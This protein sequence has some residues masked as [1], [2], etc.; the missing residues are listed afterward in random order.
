[1]SNIV[2]IPAYNEQDSIG[3]VIKDL[4]KNL[5]HRIIVVNN[6]STDNTSMEASKAGAMVVNE[7]RQ[8]YGSACLRGIEFAMQFDPKTLIFLDADYS[9]YPQEISLLIDQIEQGYDFVVGSR[10]LGQAEKNSLLPQAIFGNFLATKLMRLLFK[11][12]KFS[13]L[14]PFRAIKTQALKK[15][16]MKD[17]DFGWTVEMQI[18][19]IVKNLKIAEVSVSYRK[20]IGESKIS[21]TIHGSLQAGF[22]IL[23]TI[24]KYYYELKIS[25]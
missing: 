1:M 11:G 20:R 7:T 18:K 15:L 14:G 22:K 25:R 23:Y 8:G 6:N 10:N 3:L 13:D 4:P 19:A 17:K 12:F 24:F 9:D 16:N 21:G 5:C 2:I